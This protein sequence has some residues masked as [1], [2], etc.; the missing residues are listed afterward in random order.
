MNADGT[1]DES[2]H[3]TRR[4]FGAIGASFLLSVFTALG[5]GWGAAALVDVPSKD[6]VLTADASLLQPVTDYEVTLDD[7]DNVLSP[8]REEQLFT[9]AERLT[10]PS[11][12]TGVHFM[13]FA[14]NDTKVNDTVE[15]FIR[16]NRPEL[17]APDDDHF[18][19][20]ALIVGVGL[21]PRQSFVFAGEDVADAL[22]LGGQD[23]HLEN[24]YKAI[25][26][27]VIND[28]IAAGLF[29]GAD[30]AT[31][32]EAVVE[33]TREE[34]SG[35][36]T[37]AFVGAGIAGGAA[38][39]FGGGALYLRSYRR[40]QKIA[41]ARADASAA[42]AAY[43]E[44]AFALDELNIRAHSLS[45]TFLD[46]NLREQWEQ[47]HREFVDLHDAVDSF[48]ALTADSS[49]AEFLARADDIAKA[50]DLSQ[51]VSYAE[52]NINTIFA[53]ENGDVDEREKQVKELR[54][55]VIIAQMDFEG[56]AKK[57]YNPQILERLKK[58]EGDLDVL[59]TDV[60]APDFLDWFVSVL[61]DYQLILKEIAEKEFADVE[62]RE[63][64]TQPRIDDARYRPGYGVND[65]V[66][67]WWL[68]SWHTTNVQRD[69]AI[70][71][72]S[73]SSTDSS[74]SS[75]FSGSGGSG[76]F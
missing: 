37:T 73:S 5:A 62:D 34:A 57:Y 23:V 16:A 41:Q 69:T 8:Q 49:D 3:E 12:V 1:R 24:S 15:Y 46:A 43:T 10:V 30:Y 13:V 40:R 28:N 39:F 18:A 50:K 27:G 65:F 76:S 60:E 74:F 4:A 56:E 33:D 20:G 29:A 64:L 25:Q 48:S 2:S 35:S 17:I 19:N 58:L 59:A 26:P 54:K 6:T 53:V 9:D 38:G 42:A 32:L 21:S 45:D 44:R 22:H 63:K 36:Q 72:S 51:R 66:P 14:T 11:V 52:E 61:S 68:A 47:V 31:D 70:R 67:Y 55:D 75:G 7:P 71:E